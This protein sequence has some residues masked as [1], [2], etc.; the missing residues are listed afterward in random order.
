M[1]CWEIVR[2]IEDDCRIY[3]ITSNIFLFYVPPY[4]P[5]L[6][7]KD[8]FMYGRK[9][10]KM[11]NEWAIDVESVIIYIYY[12]VILYVFYAVKHML[13]SRRICFSQNRYVS[14]LIAFQD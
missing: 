6:S 13:Q 9:T 14:M 10:N 2:T 7:V 12:V 3:N 1:K 11:V 8:M 5:L 4:V